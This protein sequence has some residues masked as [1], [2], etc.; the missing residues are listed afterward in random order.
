MRFCLYQ[1]FAIIFISYFLNSAMA[2]PCPENTYQNGF[3]SEISTNDNEGPTAQFKLNGNF[4]EEVSAGT[5]SMTPSTDL[6][7][8]Y[9]SEVQLQNVLKISDTTSG[10]HVRLD[11]FSSSVLTTTGTNKDFA[12]AFWFKVENT[13]G[14]TWLTMM[15]TDTYNSGHGGFRIYANRKGANDY[16]IQINAYRPPQSASRAYFAGITMEDVELKSY[17]FNFEHSA[18]NGDFLTYNV[19]LFVDGVA[20]SDNPESITFKPVNTEFYLF[21]DANDYRFEH[22]YYKDVRIYDRALSLPETQTR[23][24]KVCASCPAG[25]KSSPGRT[26]LYDCTALS[27]EDGVYVSYWS[28]RKSTCP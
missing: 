10:S 2:S 25:S 6:V 8:T 7:Y 27:C 23:V 20:S 17:V 21:D 4:D 14:S 16:T 5:Y 28:I 18:T 12:I 13:A 26:S 11:G 22:V 1:N 24:V 19:K 3:L 15:Q 9:V